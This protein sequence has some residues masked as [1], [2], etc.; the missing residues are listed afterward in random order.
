MA[1]QI[2]KLTA[3]ST[4]RETKP[5]TYGDGGG[6]YL[7]VTRTRSKNFTFRYMIGGKA[8]WMG[9]G[10]THTTDLAEARHKARRAGQSLRCGVA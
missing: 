10:A 3:L 9:L 5:G 4:K 7:V 8:H 1:R 6:L 2:G